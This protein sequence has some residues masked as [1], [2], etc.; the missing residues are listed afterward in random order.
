MC[1][2]N[3]LQLEISIALKTHPSHIIAWQ[4]QQIN[5]ATLLGHQRRDHGAS[6]ETQ[7]ETGDIAIHHFVCKQS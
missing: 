2:L 5:V 4:N 6:L 1:A 3:G 7:K